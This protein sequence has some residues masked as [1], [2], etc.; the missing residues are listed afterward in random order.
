MNI[1]PLIDRKTNSSYE[2]QSFKPQKTH[3][4]QFYNRVAFVSE[5]IYQYSENLGQYITKVL[6]RGEGMIVMARSENMDVI[7][8][9]LTEYNVS[10]EEVISNGQLRIIDAEGALATFMQEELPDQE[11][12]KLVIGG[13]FE[14]MSSLFPNICAYGE[15]TGIL[16][17]EGKIDATVRIERLWDDLSSVYQFNLMCGYSLHSFSDSKHSVCFNRINNNHAHHPFQDF[18]SKRPDE[19][20][21]ILTVLEQQSRTLN[22]ELLKSRRMSEQLKVSEAFNKSIVD[23]SHDCIQ[24]LDLNGKILFMNKGGLDAIEADDFQELNGLTW[25]QIWPKSEKASAMEALRVAKSGVLGQHSG[26]SP[27]R[28]TRT[29]KYWHVTLSLIPGVDGEDKVLAVARDITTM[30][31]LETQL[32][33]AVRSRD[34]LMSI[35]SHELKT[36]L[37]ALRLQTGLLKMKINSGDPTIFTPARVEKMVGDY[38]RQVDRL[39]RLVDEM[40]DVTRINSGKMCFNFENVKLSSLIY[41]VLDRMSD[42]LSAAGCEVTVHAAPGVEGMWDR[43]RM[44]HVLMNLL[45]NAMKYGSKKPIEIRAGRTTNNTAVFTVR[46]YGMGIAKENQERIFN[47]FERAI[48]ANEVSGLGLGLYIV[49]QI[50]EAHQGTIQV[51]SDEGAGSSFIVELPIDPVAT[52]GK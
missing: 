13:L 4:T 6:D 36:P 27:T 15:M 47:R 37:T 10:V 28:K 21:K 30:K 49:K 41:E 52:S 35:C 33:Q 12:F 19:Q 32:L 2:Y 44:E 14:K 18:S 7:K 22:A 40:L 42:Q 39:V 25:E 16:W 38:G 45:T 50:V 20:A 29:M 23:S 8:Q 24:I 51:I 11:K 48:S 3:F 31:K 17:D 34:D 1:L 46:D 26:C 9:A 5:S 43:F